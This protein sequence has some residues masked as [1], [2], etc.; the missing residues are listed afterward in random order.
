MRLAGLSVL[1]LLVCVACDGSTPDAEESQPDYLAQT[2]GPVTRDD[3]GW[4]CEPGSVWKASSR[5]IELVSFGFWQGSTGYRAERGT[6]NAAQQRALAG[7]CERPTPTGPVV[8]DLVSYHIKVT[9]ADGSVVEYR[10]VPDN[11]LE[12]D[13]RDHALRTI[14]YD[15]LEPFL[16]AFRCLV[17][18]ESRVTRATKID[19]E[20][21]WATAPTLPSDPSCLNG[22]FAPYNCGESWLKLTV[23]SAKR[24]TLTTERCVGTLQIKVF[25]ATG[26][27]ELAT[28]PASA[29]PRCPKLSYA[30]SAGT[31]Y[32][33]LRKTNGTQS[34]DVRGA[35]GD[36]LLR[37]SSP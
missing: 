7:L 21:P 33:Q 24:Q 18:S 10:A 12:G 6:L 9:D 37:V 14:D 31:Y 19:P 25:D 13:E 32:V 36:Y 17:A 26:E 2:I 8:S 11:A 1:A 29:S 15:S 5:R 20:R 23:P 35:A 28:S 16:K 4:T 3:S 34:C 27:N 22:V 30:F